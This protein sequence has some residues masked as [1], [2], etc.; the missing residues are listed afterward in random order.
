V[1]GKKTKEIKSK[2]SRKER[3]K[4]D[5]LLTL[6]PSSRPGEVKRVLIRSKE[7]K[8]LTFLKDLCDSGGSKKSSFLISKERESW[9][10][11]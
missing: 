5:H 2:S 11:I 1:L 3:R 9:Y 10:P 4:R 8:W 7:E 6:S